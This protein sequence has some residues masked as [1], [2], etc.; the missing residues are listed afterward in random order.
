MLEG[1]L[2]E[3][4]E[5]GA[6]VQCAGSCH[7][8]RVLRTLNA[9]RRSGTLTH[10]VLRAGDRDFACH[11]AALGA[12]GSAY[13]RSLFTAWRP[14]G[15]PAAVPTVP[16]TPGVRRTRAALARAV[17]LDYVYGAGLRLR[18][19]DEEAAAVL[20]LAHRLG[21][22]GLREACS[23]F[24][25]EDR[26]R[27]TNS[28]ALR[29][30]AAAF[31]LPSLAER[32]SLVLR[33]TFTEVLRHTDFL[34]LAPDE[35][36]ALLTDPALGVAREEAVFEVA[37]QWVRHDTQARCGELRRLLEHVRLPLL[38][39]EHFLQKVEAD[40]LLQTCSDPPLLLEAR[41]C[42]ILGEASALCT[43]PRRF[44]DLAEEIVVIGGCD[45]NGLLKL[46]FADAYHPESQCWT[47]PPG[48]PGYMRSEFAACTLR[49]D[50]YVSA[51]Q[52]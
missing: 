10:V 46:P 9:Y 26:L 49:N 5:A 31:S 25:L 1:P 2:L 50:I 42:F 13:F 45:H 52:S 47:P 28:L 37:M 8:Q 16:Q 24:F 38:A 48:L 11:R 51:L 4:S 41:A 33:H 35:V 14:V 17:V 22:A 18:A 32:C 34:E 29:G 36:A 23:Y 19:E 12:A 7:V 43:R 21:M 6:V 20:E 15:G 3:E 27:V 44:M 39:P 40:E 30:V